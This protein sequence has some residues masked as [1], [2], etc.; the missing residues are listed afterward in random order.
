MTLKH[1]KPIVDFKKPTKRK[2][3]SIA[4]NSLRNIHAAHVAVFSN[5]RGEVDNPEA[6]QELAG[7]ELA[8]KILP[9]AYGRKKK[10]LKQ[11]GLI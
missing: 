3:I 8:L 11:H 5:P 1:W 4:R 10:E 9:T 7:L 6:A 2:A